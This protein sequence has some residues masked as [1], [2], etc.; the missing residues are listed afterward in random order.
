MKDVHVWR[1]MES[2]QWLWNKGSA[3]FLAVY[4]SARLEK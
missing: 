1:G 4:S 2:W 3:L